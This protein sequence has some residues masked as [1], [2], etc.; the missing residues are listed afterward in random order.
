[1]HARLPVR[2]D[3]IVIGAGAAGV[4]AMRELVRSGLHRHLRRGPQSHRGTHFHPALSRASPDRARG[5]IRARRRQHRSPALP[6]VWPDFGSACGK[7]Y[8]W[9]DGQLLSR[10]RFAPSTATGAARTPPFG[11]AFS[12]RGKGSRTRFTVFLRTPECAELLARSAVTQRTSSS[13]Q[14]R[15]FRRTDRA[16]TRRLARARRHRV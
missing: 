6:R 15:S 1:M 11:G 10:L 7:A 5:G 14:E 16:H 8:S 4:F 2:A 9:F 3:V 12:T 13:S